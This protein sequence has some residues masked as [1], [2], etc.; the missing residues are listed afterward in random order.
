MN[1]YVKLS[2]CGD[3]MCELPQLIASKNKFR[4]NFNGEFNNINSLLSNSDYVIGNL[5]TPISKKHLYTND[6]YC[7]NTPPSFL[8]E[9]KKNYF[10]LLITANNHC[11]D[12]GI[13]GLND[14]MKNIKK[15]GLEYVGT[16]LKKDDSS[17]LIKDVLGIKIAFLAYTYGTNYSYNRY[18]LREKDSYKVNFLK[19]QISDPSWKKDG[20]R[21]YIFLY[22]LKK[23]IKNIIKSIIRYNNKILFNNSV[24]VDTESENEWNF[25]IDK[26]NSIKKDIIEAKK[27]SDLVF[28]SFH[29][30][31][32]FNNEPG[33]FSKKL[34]KMFEDTNYDCIIGTHA[35]VVQK[36]E[37]SNNKLNTYCLGNLSI[38]P[39][40]PYLVKEE[41]PECS[42]ILHAYID[43]KTKK[44]IKYTFSI[45]KA[46]E[47]KN[48]F[49][50]VY[51]LNDLIK[52]AKSNEEYKRLVKENLFI[53][54]RFTNQSLNDILLKDEYDLR[55]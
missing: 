47:N 49:L 23:Q 48:H 14:T 17:F 21:K 16:K 39:S 37:F 2:F 43:K 36:C 33:D 27:K 22:T 51:L 15:N 12:R 25:D 24:V 32:Q 30:G 9:L 44:I 31:G 6:L 28:L 55:L 38:S 20:N 11:L 3:I 52:N 13:S 42:V 40:T 34:F 5:E 50:Q 29:V 41:L 46:V 19:N 8:A 4:Y 26:V 53:Y 45:L 54:N 7:F 1:K 35:H 10:D 18:D